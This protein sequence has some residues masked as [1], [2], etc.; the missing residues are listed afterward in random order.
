[1]NI[2]ELFCFL[3][4]KGAVVELSYN[5]SS[6]YDYLFNFSHQEMDEWTVYNWEFM[7]EDVTSVKFIGNNIY[8]DVR[9]IKG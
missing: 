3:E 4:S 5:G 8:I 9:K 2:H 1:M 7:E 6:C